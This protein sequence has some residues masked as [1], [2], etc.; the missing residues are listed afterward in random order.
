MHDS[1]G[2]IRIS[3]LG[4]IATRACRDATAS[5]YITA[6]PNRIAPLRSLYVMR[7]FTCFNLCR[8]THR[9]LSLPIIHR[10]R[11]LKSIEQI[12]SVP[13]PPSFTPGPALSVPRATAR[14]RALYIRHAPTCRLL[15]QLTRTDHLSELT[16]QDG[17]VRRH[18]GPHGLPAS[19]R[20]CAHGV[21]SEMPSWPCRATPCC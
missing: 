9:Y 10:R 2:Q 16:Q 3:D 5:T 1:V 15:R 18:V 19:L 21:N 20:F 7:L 17:V 13:C 6:V 4:K 12:P 14:V 8:A 11:L